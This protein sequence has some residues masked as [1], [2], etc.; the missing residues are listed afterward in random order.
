MGVDLV[1]ALNSFQE[2]RI[3]SFIVGFKKSAPDLVGLTK[4]IARTVFYP[5]LVPIVGD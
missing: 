2:C 1:N 3:D 5:I 4:N